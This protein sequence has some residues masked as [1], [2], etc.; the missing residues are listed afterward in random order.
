MTLEDLKLILQKVEELRSLLVLT[1]RTMPFLEDVFAFIRE[2]VPLVEELKSSVET[3]SDKLPKA[4][5][6]LDKVTTATELATTEI[7]TI[8]EGLFT[9]V[10]D[11]Q[12]AMAADRAL[13]DAARASGRTVEE[14]FRARTGAASSEAADAA[15]AAAW[16]EHLRLINTPLPTDPCRATLESIQNDCTNIMIALQ[17]QDITAQQIAAVNRLMQSVDDGLGR[18]L[19][20]FTKVHAEEDPSR[21][22]H[23]RL[24][25]VFDTEAE[26]TA[27]TERQKAADAVV[28]ASR[29]RPRAPKG[30]PRSKRSRAS[31]KQSR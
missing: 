31:R 22:H 18:L 26:Y 7:L 14:L 30:R 3:T 11:I 21:F 19:R 8:V 13:V 29:R 25:I 2:L 27:G 1:E 24:D 9:K 17:V 15:L 28:E 23:Q 20:N 5:K 6:Q 4:S 16:A 10:Q 12:K